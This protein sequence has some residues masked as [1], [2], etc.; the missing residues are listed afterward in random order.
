M[1]VKIIFPRNEN[2]SVTATCSDD[3]FVPKE[4]KDGENNDRKETN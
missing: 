4:N 2:N 1:P 3:G